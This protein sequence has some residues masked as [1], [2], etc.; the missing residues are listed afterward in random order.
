M[1]SFHVYLREPTLRPRRYVLEI[2]PEEQ[3]EL[4][5]TFAPVAREYRRRMRVAKFVVAAALGCLLLGL[6]VPKLLDPWAVAGFLSCWVML[7]S[8]AF[9]SPKLLCPAC[10][11][12]IDKG[13]GPFCPECGADALQRGGWFRA[14]RCSTRGRAMQVGRG[15]ARGYKIRACTHCGMWLDDKGLYLRR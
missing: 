10:A 14:P 9:L 3:A 13:L 2:P 5:A 6:V 1:K 11:N 8:I 12:K 7:V 4:R 15:N